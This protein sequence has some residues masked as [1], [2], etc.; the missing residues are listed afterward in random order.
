MEL[1]GSQS[2]PELRQKATERAEAERKGKAERAERQ[3]ALL[4]PTRVQAAREERA[5]A[6]IKSM[7][8]ARQVAEQ[9]AGQVAGHVA[10]RWRWV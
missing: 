5:R 2:A 9:V 3:M 10:G 6:S 1:N 7:Q 4:K 8:V